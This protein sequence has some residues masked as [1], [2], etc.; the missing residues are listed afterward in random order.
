MLGRGFSSDRFL[1]S[2]FPQ[3]RIPVTPTQARVCGLRVTGS[4]PPGGPS[5]VRGAKWL[6]LCSRF[7]AGPPLLLAHCHRKVGP[8][9]PTSP[10][11]PRSF[12]SPLALDRQGSIRDAESPLVNRGVA[13]GHPRAPRPRSAR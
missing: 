13:R 10:G 1:I 4:A 3:C 2:R 12:F 7:D 6:R 5:T 8:L 9:P 11:L